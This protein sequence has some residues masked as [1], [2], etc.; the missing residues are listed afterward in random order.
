MVNKMPNKMVDSMV[1]YKL[2]M[3]DCMTNV[4]HSLW[5]TPEQDSLVVF[6]AACPCNKVH[7]ESWCLC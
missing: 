7:H 6:R 1:N 2:M 4:H 5:G 3:V